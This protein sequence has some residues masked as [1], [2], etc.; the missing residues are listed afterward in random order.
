[1]PHQD[2]GEQHGQRNDGGHDQARPDIAQEEDQHDKHDQ[3]ALDQVA[4]D[5]RYVAVHQFRAVQVG[6]DAHPFGQHLLHLLDPFLQLLGDG[7]G[8]GALQHHGD[9]ADTLALAIFRH[10]AEALGRPET[11]LSDVA[12]MHRDAAPVGDDDPF[13][14]TQFLNHTFRT[15]VIGPVDLLNVASSRV[16]VVLAQ[17]FEDLADGEV[18]G[19]EHI[20]IDRH[21]ILLEVASEAVDLDDARDAGQ[22]ALDDPVLDRAQLHGVVARLITGRHFQDIL[23][24]LAQSG[25]D[26]HQ[27][28]RAQLGRDLANNGLYLLVDQ[29][30]G[31][32]RRDILLEYD[33]HERQAEAG[34]RTDLLH[35]HDITHRD[36]D[37]E[38]DQLLHFLRGKGG[39]D[40]NDLHL[41]V[42]DVGY[43]VDRQRH[44]RVDSPGQQ[45]NR[46]QCDE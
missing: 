28:G 37:R 25:R 8:I 11:D 42:G 3:G 39:R 41:V 6:L 15:D 43:R 27:L 1:M 29:L 36:L 33:R 14:V 9:T 2:E 5:G 34:D 13:D 21:L 40:G 7:V 35:V 22:L 19:V 16:L 31:I 26:G 23:I 4:D 10:G 44:H 17:G 12:D 24:D 32:E 18:H 45:E 20:G 38:G 46:R 30:A